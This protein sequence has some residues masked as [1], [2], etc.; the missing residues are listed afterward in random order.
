MQDFFQEELALQISILCRISRRKEKSLWML[1][2][3]SH[4]HTEMV[5]TDEGTA[6]RTLA[7]CCLKPT[8]FSPSLCVYT[9]RHVYVCS[10][11]GK[12][13]GMCVS[14]NTYMHVPMRRAEDTLDCW[15]SGAAHLHLFFWRQYSL[16]AWNSSSDWASPTQAYK[17]V[18]FTISRFFF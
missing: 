4:Q 10:Y 16:L 5:R 1:S 14:D 18:L 6:W 13:T 9:C 3:W 12:C 8:L 15:S 11:V 17:H 7:Q 2:N